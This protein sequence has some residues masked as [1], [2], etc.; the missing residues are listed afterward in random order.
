MLYSNIFSINTNQ[1]DKFKFKT[2]QLIKSLKEV[3]QKLLK[4]RCV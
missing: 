2:K 3:D 4:L 1:K